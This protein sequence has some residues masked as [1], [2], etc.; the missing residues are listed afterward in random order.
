MVIVERAAEEKALPAS[1]GLTESQLLRYMCDRDLP[2]FLNG[3]GKALVPGLSPTELSLTNRM[4]TWDTR[5]AGAA[6]TGNRIAR[7]ESARLR[8]SVQV[9]SPGTRFDVRDSLSEHGVHRRKAALPTGIERS[10][11]F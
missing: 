2:G 7:G 8:E 10:R 11:H 9:P 4:V 6:A 5:T 1:D 3:L